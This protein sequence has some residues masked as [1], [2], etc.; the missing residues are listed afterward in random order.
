M[1]FFRMTDS[2][3]LHDIFTA[4]SSDGPCE[5][6]LAERNPPSVPDRSNIPRK[7][8]NQLKENVVKHGK[9]KSQ[10]SNT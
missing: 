9:G 6:Q 8:P 3:Q 10:S 5:A 7:A 2:D 1:W 4:E